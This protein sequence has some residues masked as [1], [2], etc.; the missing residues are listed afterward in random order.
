MVAAVLRLE[1][2]LLAAV[3]VRILNIDFPEVENEK[4]EQFSN[5][6]SYKDS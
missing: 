2:A 1:D 5:N 3:V 4:K 6:K